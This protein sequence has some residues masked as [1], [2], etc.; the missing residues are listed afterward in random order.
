VVYPSITSVHSLHKVYRTTGQTAL[1]LSLI[2]STTNKKPFE[3]S[4]VL[5]RDMVL[6]AE[7]TLTQRFKAQAFQEEQSL[8]QRHGITSQRTWPLR[9]TAV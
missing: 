8:S 1:Q 5:G 7:W 3:D 9:N 6:L 4:S 2:Y